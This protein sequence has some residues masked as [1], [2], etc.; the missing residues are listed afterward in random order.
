MRYLILLLSFWSVLAHAGNDKKVTSL[1]LL[2][3][4]QHFPFDEANAVINANGIASMNKSYFLG[5]ELTRDVLGPLMFGFRFHQHYGTEREIAEPQADPLDEAY[6][7]LNRKAYLGVAR[8]SVMRTRVAV[9]EVFGGVGGSTSKLKVHTAAFDQSFERREV[10]LTSITGVTFGVGF[11]NIYIFG[12]V[13]QEWS[14]TDNLERTPGASTALTQ[15]DT[16]GTWGSVGLLFNGI[17]S[18]VKMK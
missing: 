16:N 13:G 17:P 14:K 8:L 7:S 1:R 10:N 9:L 4:I 18:F 12:E 6:A 3:G 2:G 5:V 11:A 15:F